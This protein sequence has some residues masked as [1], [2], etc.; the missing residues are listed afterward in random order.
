[1]NMSML[2]ND[3]KIKQYDKKIKCQLYSG[4]AKLQQHIRRKHTLKALLFSIYHKA[5]FI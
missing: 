5:D 3:K 2:N 4:N 1:M